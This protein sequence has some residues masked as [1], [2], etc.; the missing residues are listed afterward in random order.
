MRFIYSRTDLPNEY[1][2]LLNQDST[3]PQQFIE[4]NWLSIFNQQI[5]SCWIVLSNHKI[6]RMEFRR[7]HG[8]SSIFYNF[9]WR[10]P[11]Q[12]LFAPSRNMSG[13]CL[14]KL[15]SSG[16]GHDIETAQSTD[17][18]AQGT[19]LYHI[20]KVRGN[21]KIS[22]EV[23]VIEYNLDKQ[24]QEYIKPIDSQGRKIVLYSPDHTSRAGPM[25]ATAHG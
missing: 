1:S 12:G 22:S 2:N 15:R 20:H 19:T 6:V 8:V 3:R 25:D 14:S 24:D 21:V 10:H 23:E 5:L 17:T 11:A 4:F 18:A 7:S 13:I 9:Y 16:I